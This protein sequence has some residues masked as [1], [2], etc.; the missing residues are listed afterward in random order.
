M[1]NNPPKPK[2]GGEHPIYGIFIGGSELDNTYNVTGTRHYRL[3]GQRRGPKV[4]NS[5]EQ[6]L[7]KT[8]DSNEACKF[9]GN[10]EKTELSPSNEIDKENFI[11]QLQKKVRFHL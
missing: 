4:V 7:L 9:N 1:T 10:L 11:K 3:T 2:R 8:I 5:I 6:A